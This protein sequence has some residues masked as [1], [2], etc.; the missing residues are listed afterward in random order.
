MEMLLMTKYPLKVVSFE[1]L[2]RCDFYVVNIYAQEMKMNKCYYETKNG[3]G[4]NGFV[5]VKKGS[6]RY[7][8]GD[9]SVE[10][11]EG[12]LIYLPKMSHHKCFVTSED[13]SYIRIDFQVLTP[14]KEEIIFSTVPMVMNTSDPQ[15]IAVLAKELCGGYGNYGA[16]KKFKL[17][18][19]LYQLFY[20]LS[21]DEIHPEKRRIL[22]KI[23]AGIEYIEKTYNKDLDI[24]TAA[25]LCNLSVSRFRNLFRQVTGHSVL[26]YRENLRME[27]ACALIKTHSYS[28]GEIAEL[29][30]Y[31]NVYY[32]SYRFKKHYGV[33]P[34]K[35]VF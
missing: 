33:P 19:K 17:V 1:N 26:E 21:D 14:E 7:V 13:Y 12:S 29:L 9:R 28:M 18:S 23:S 34:S 22:N 5:F 8:F 30:G 10:L 35:Y 16:K 15:R 32:F 20:T 27:Q 24:D 3:R 4:L 11:I 31:A 25:G 2:N 6:C